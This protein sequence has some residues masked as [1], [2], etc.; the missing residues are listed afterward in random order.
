MNKELKDILTN[1][2][3]VLATQN[4]HNVKSTDLHEETDNRINSLN[5]MMNVII[6]AVVV[7]F[8]FIVYLLIK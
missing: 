8:G 2:G 5:F 1:I 4:V 7:E 6:G 3:N